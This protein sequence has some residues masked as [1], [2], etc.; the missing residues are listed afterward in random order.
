MLAAIAVM[1]GQDRAM[2]ERLHA[3]V[4]SSSPELSPKTWYGMPAYATDGKVVC[5]FQSAAKFKSRYATIGFSDRANLD[6][7]D[8]WPTSFALKELTDAE[9]MR[10]LRPA[11]ARGDL[12]EDAAGETTG[13]GFTWRRT[14][15]ADRVALLRR[16][17]VPTIGLALLFGGSPGLGAGA[18][19]TGTVATPLP[20]VRGPL[21]VTDASYP[22]NAAAHGLTPIDLSARRY[23]EQE[24]LIDGTANI[25]S[26]ASSGGLEVDAVRA[27]RDPDPDPPPGE[28]GPVQRQRDPGADQPDL[29]L[30]RRHHVGRRP[31]L[32]HE[33]RRH[34]RRH[35][36]QAGRAGLR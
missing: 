5:F 2:A 17:L 29:E 31:R 8:M 28:P 33:P 25:Y 15:N 16:V 26:E 35:L 36:G 1:D 9:E 21:P 11:R 19:V 23:V 3:I 12:T 22:W 13:R 24:F 7:G 14:G 18:T 6:E 20:A 4:K 34:L 27:V 10:Q 32:L 30:R